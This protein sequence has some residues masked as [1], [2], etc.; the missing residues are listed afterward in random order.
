MNKNQL[1]ASPNW[2]TV[3]AQVSKCGELVSKHECDESLSFYR[4]KEHVSIKYQATEETYHYLGLRW[5]FTVVK[6]AFS[7]EVNGFRGL[8]SEIK[9]HKD[10]ITRIGYAGI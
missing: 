2:S 8:T 7:F 4:G 3:R 5:N 1:K 9:Y 6:E 10:E